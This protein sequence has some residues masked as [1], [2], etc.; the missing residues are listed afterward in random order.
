MVAKKGHGIPIEPPDLGQLD[1]CQIRIDLYNQ[2]QRR[3][4]Y[5]YEDVIR[6]QDAVTAAILVVMKRRIVKLYK[7]AK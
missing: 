3:G 2:L 1:W 5:V 7:D 6:E 4:V